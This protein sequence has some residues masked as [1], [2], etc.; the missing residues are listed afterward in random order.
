MA[1]MRVVQADVVGERHVRCV[2]A[3]SFGARVRAIAFRAVDGPLAPLLLDRRGPP[4]HLVGQLRADS[5][6]GARRTQFE[7]RDVAAPA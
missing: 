4:I 5:W 6:N 2:V 7:I 1:D 3:D